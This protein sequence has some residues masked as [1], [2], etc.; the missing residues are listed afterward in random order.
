MVQRKRTPFFSVLDRRRLLLVNGRDNRRRVLESLHKK[1]LKHEHTELMPQPKPEETK[2]A[3]MNRCL[4]EMSKDYPN[5]DQRYAYCIGVWESERL[6][7]QDKLREYFAESFNDYP[8]AVSNNAKKGIE[9]NEKV[10]NKCA[11]QVGKVRAQQLAKNEKITLETI[12]RMYSYLSRAETYYD[13]GDTKSCG[14]ISFML[15]G[16]LAGKR[17]AESKL[18]E[19]G[20]LK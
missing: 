6:T 9:L 14:Y 13:K 4:K 3:Y 1:R 8:E 11:T 12:K 15:W 19:L 18:K 17:W 5:T 16:G 2:N 10:N 7:P 20:E